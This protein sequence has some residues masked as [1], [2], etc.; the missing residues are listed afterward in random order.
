M[1]TTIVGIIALGMVSIDYA[2]HT[3]EQ[4]QSRSALVSL[5][6]SATLTDITTI[7]RQ[8]YGPV[9]TN[10]IQMAAN[11]TVDNTNYVCIYR[12]VNPATGAANLT[13]SVF[14]DDSWTCYTR[15]G[16]NLHK[17]VRTVAAGLGNCVAAD[18][19][20]GT[21]TTDVFNAT[22]PNMSV[23]LFTVYIKNRYDPTQAMA[24]ITNPEIAMVGQVLPQ[25]CSN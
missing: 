22:P 6:T 25:A 4:Q 18:P 3:N 8:A 16:T 20:I 9:T 23:N 14:T 17:C 7:A 10:C 24:Y 13:P 12:D 1:T 11:M 2:L 21:V 15:R 19:V 5:R